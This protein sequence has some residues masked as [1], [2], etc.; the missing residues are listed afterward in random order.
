MPQVESTELAKA[1]G[2]AI[3]KQRNRCGLSQ[4]KVAEK[5]GIGLE[6]VSRIERGV[7]MPTVSRLLELATIFECEAV[8]LLN[9]SSNRPT[10]QANHISSLLAELA[11]DDRQLVIELL[12]RLV[13]RLK[14]H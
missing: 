4:D 8:D 6:A 7:V 5:L 12:E 10:D 14:R 9:E 13:E 11:S 1:V 3:A 2:R